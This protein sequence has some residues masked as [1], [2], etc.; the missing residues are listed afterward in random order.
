MSAPAGDLALRVE[1]IVDVTPSVRGFVLRP[2]DGGGLPSYAPGSHLVVACGDRRNAYSLTG[3]G[4]APDSYAISVLHRPD[5]QGGSAWLHGVRPGQVLRCG[6]PRDAFAPVATARHHLLIAGGIGITPFLSHLWAARR[7]GRRVSVLYA[8]GAG[9]PVPHHAELTALAGDGLRILRGRAAMQ[10]AMDQALRTQALGTHLYVCGPDGLMDSA[11]AL[12][13]GHGWPDERCHAERFG[14][15]DAAEGAPFT[16]RLRRTGRDIA[17]AADASLLDALAAAGVEWPAMCRRGV[18]GE[19]RMDNAAGTILHRDLVL[20]PA[21][22][23]AQSCLM[24]CVSRAEGVLSL[25]L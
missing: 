21:E 2:A 12:A 24:P 3:E 22:R 23:A 7:W 17:V 8:V 19:C 10:A 5:G 25:D 16:V 15:V 1:R 18:C 13:R 20:S 6:R 4:H 11:L 14:G 9:A